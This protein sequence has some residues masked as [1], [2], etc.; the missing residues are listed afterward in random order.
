MQMTIEQLQTFSVAVVAARNAKKN[1][2]HEENCLPHQLN[3]MVHCY[4]TDA[5]DQD[6]VAHLSQITSYKHT[7]IDQ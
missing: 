4:Q 7:L 3:E 5:S 2:Q 1:Q 6:D